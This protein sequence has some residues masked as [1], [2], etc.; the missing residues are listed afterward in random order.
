MQLEAAVVGVDSSILG[1]IGVVDHAVLGVR[2]EGMDFHI[3]VGRE[4]LVE[5]FLTVSSPQD[6]AVQ[7][8]AVLKGVRQAGDIN[9]AAIAEAVC[10]HLHFLILLNQDLSTFVSKD[11]LLAFAEVHLTGHIRQDEVIGIALPVVLIVVQGE[12]GFLLH[13]QNR[14]QLQVMTLVLMTGRLTNTDKAAAVMD[15][16]ANCGRNSGI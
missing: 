10:C 14:S 1:Y 4:P 9:A 16:L 12:A 5:N 11:A 13:T 2:N 15:K 8:T 7:N 6:R 3:V